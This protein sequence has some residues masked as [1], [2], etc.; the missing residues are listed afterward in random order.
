MTLVY[1]QGHRHSSWIALDYEYQFVVDNSLANQ[2][3]SISM[4]TG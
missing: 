2:D 3:I 4:L 1:F